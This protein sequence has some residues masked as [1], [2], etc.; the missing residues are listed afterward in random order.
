MMPWSFSY[1]GVRL[2]RSRCSRG[3]ALGLMAEL[4]LLCDPRNSNPH[5]PLGPSLCTSYVPAWTLPLSPSDA[6]RKSRL[7][8]LFPATDAGSGR[9]SACGGLNAV[10]QQR[11]SRQRAEHS[12]CGD[13]RRR[14]GSSCSSDEEED[15]H[16]NERQ[17]HLD[18]GRWRRR[19][20]LRQRAPQA[21]SARAPGNP[22]GTSYHV[23][24]CAFPDM[25]PGRESECGADLAAPVSAWTVRLS[26]PAIRTSTRSVT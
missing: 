11:T 19:N 20:R 9:C 10:P 12:R 16:G 7:S 14:T 21:P 15:T 1:H 8:I 4:G 5:D 13:A 26:R 24:V 2:T 3:P 18:P 6:G 17:Q 25:A 22:G 23:R